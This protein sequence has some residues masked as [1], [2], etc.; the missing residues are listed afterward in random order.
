MEK[1][2]AV[3]Y[4]LMAAVCGVLAFN[5]WF[6]RPRSLLDIAGLRGQE[7]E[8]IWVNWNE[9][10]DDYGTRVT[11]DPDEI[12][13]YLSALDEVRFQEEL[14]FGDTVAL[15]GDRIDH[16]A[17]YRTE[18]GYASFQYSNGDGTMVYSGPNF[19]RV[20]HITG[21]PAQLKPLFDMVDTWPEAENS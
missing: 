21:D 16:F 6:G 1:K 5:L 14:H 8:R 20:F 10:L 7:V 9:G 18:G 13:A 2:K 4:L 11:G 19:S 15:V 3:W 17:V 12:G